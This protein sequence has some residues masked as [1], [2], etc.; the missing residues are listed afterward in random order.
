MTMTFKTGIR[1]LRFVGVMIFLFSC[2]SQVKKV[3]QATIGRI[4]MMPNQPAPYKMTDWYEKAH[5]FDEY[6]YNVDLKGEYLP[7][8]WIDDAKRNLPQKT[9]G[10]YTAIGDVRQGQKGNKEF[11]EALCTIG[12]LLSAGLVGIDKTNQNG[13]NYVKMVQNYFNSAN[14][15]N[16]MMD[17][18]S[19]DVAK[20]GGGYG[21]DWWYDV[22]PN[23]LYYGLCELF[24]NVNGADS[25][26]RIIAEKFYKADSALN[27]NYD[28]SFFDY[29][30]MKGVSNHIP[31]QQDAAAGHAYVLLCAYEKFKDERYLQGAKS[32]MNAFANQKESRF[33]EV[34]MPFGALVAARLNAEHG[35]N[36][37]VKKILDWT[38]DGCKATDGRTGW[39]VIAERWGEY[40]VYGLQGSI[41][42]G[43]GYAFLMNSFDLAWPLV[44]M[45]RYDNHYADAIGKWML[46][47][48]NAARL[49]Y[50]YEI[51][52]R[53]QWLPDKKAITKNVIA[54]E[55]LR[56]DDHFYKKTSLNGLSPVALGDGPQWAKGQ[57]E[58]SMFSLYSS[59]QAGIFGAIVKKTNV[60]KIL[61]INCNATDF[62]QAHAFP[63][64][65][66]YNPYDT[67]KS[68]CYY[69]TRKSKVDL[70]DVLSHE[71][72]SKDI[73]EETCFEI[74]SK[75]SRLIVLIPSGSQV[76][77]KGGNY[78]VG[79]RVV[80]F[81]Q[82]KIR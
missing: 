44:P 82:D 43:G 11:H 21:R 51:D 46:N 68:V 19:S 65:L 47:V 2:T 55:G 12:S 15:W 17:N 36:Y 1:Y 48:T 67:A 41:T 5:N 78:M 53:H 24:P 66:Y 29:G 76:Q 70:Y 32:A 35:T 80:A 4:A 58:V 33:Y 22:F 7:F 73:T 50:P 72:V 30:Q 37:D 18:T 13:F 3:D 31:H 56:K 34:L 63:T 14:G 52:D 26:Q 75:S 71:Y 57:P 60:E 20:L 74:P 79:S 62:Y 10:I 28:Y 9:F 81:N 59:A 27:G 42:D 6:V 25:L 69:N 16:I 64:Y 38:F 49:F 40:D 54:Y 8:V 39:G 77:R 45:V 23:V 61:Q